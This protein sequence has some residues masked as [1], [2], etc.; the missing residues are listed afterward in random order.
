MALI[1]VSLVTSSII[2]LLSD[3]FSLPAS[4]WQG[5]LIST[6]ADSPPIIQA[7]AIS[8]D[9]PA[10]VTDGLSFYL[11]HVQQNPQ[12]K[13]TVPKGNDASPVKYTPL[14][15]NLFYILSANSS[16][17]PAAPVEQLMMGIAMKA[18]HDFP[19]VND[20]THV[21][22]D[23][24]DLVMNAALIGANNHFRIS[25]QPIPFNEAVH[26]WTAGQSPLKLSAYYEIS[27]VCLEP[28]ESQSIAGRVLTY[29]TYVFP[30]GAPKITASRNTISFPVPFIAKPQKIDLQPAQ[31]TPGG[32]LDFLGSGFLGEDIQ[33]RLCCYYYY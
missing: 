32:Q 3:A 27:V 28:Q 26:Y 2:K 22:S 4:G 23:S 31:V 12:F 29:G 13:N 25:L 17:E 30:E 19:V 1:D 5:T 18:L 6:G 20:V 33:Q 14:A 16:S 11:Y 15:L 24:T 21:K 7:P 8:P 10:K 9:P